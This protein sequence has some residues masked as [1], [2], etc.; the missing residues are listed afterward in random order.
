MRASASSALRAA[1]EVA[2][3]PDPGTPRHFAYLYTAVDHRPALLALLAIER[4]VAASAAASSHEV[5]HA[6][7]QWWQ[8]ECDRLANG[9]GVH[10][11]SRALQ[12]AARSG[13]VSAPDLRPWTQSVAQT[14]ARATWT[15][16]GALDAHCALWADSIWRQV[17]KLASE[18]DGITVDDEFVLASG[19][20]L[21]QL[22]LLGRLSRDARDGIISLPLNELA[23]FGLR[24]EDCYAQ[25]WPTGLVSLVNARIGQLRRALANSVEALPR[26]AWPTLRA[27]ASWIASADRAASRLYER[28]PPQPSHGALSFRSA[29]GDVIAAWRAARRSL[30]GLAPLTP[31]A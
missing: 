8:F 27:P 9:Q 12:A 14:L 1:S 28:E 11:L 3:P 22:E 10:P 4:E 29:I 23:A 20:A 31:E 15:D 13:A 21:R 7:L 19:K 5:A 16:R 18:N 2:A 6:R 17:I 30:R 26:A 25:P 24:S